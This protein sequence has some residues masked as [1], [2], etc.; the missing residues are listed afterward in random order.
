MLFH[1]WTRYYFQNWKASIHKYSPEGFHVRL[2]RMF[3]SHAR[4][5]SVHWGSHGGGVGGLGRVHP[6]RNIFPLTLREPACSPP[7]PSDTP[8]TPLSPPPPPRRSTSASDWPPGSINET[9]STGTSHRTH[10]DSKALHI[11]SL[12]ADLELQDSI[13]EQLFRCKLHTLERKCS[14]GV[15]KLRT[16]LEELVLQGGL[17][18]AEL[19]EK[20]KCFLTLRRTLLSHQGY[21]KPARELLRLFPDADEDLAPL[22]C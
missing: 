5:S 10:L 21:S 3:A 17:P 20:T 8:F 18:L 7:A 6:R 2:S 15:E 1:E 12:Y 22:C 13:K 11:M 19:L 14:G 4:A 16:L 9:C